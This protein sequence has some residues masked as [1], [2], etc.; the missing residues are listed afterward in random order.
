VTDSPPPGTASGSK[1]SQKV[2]GHLVF[3]VGSPVTLDH[4]CNTAGF[5]TSHDI[6]HIAWKIQYSVDHG[7][8]VNKV[9]LA[10]KVR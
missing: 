10:A 7:T 5:Q 6:F 4:D 1:I 3:F 2:E 8:T 9:E